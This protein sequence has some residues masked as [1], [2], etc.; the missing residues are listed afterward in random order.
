MYYDIWALR[1]PVLCPTDFMTQGTVMDASLGR[2]LAVHFA[3]S[4]IQVDFRGMKG[5]LPVDSA[6][7]GMGVYRRDALGQA[8]YIGLRD[9]R[10]VCEH[11]PLH[12]QLRA[13]GKRLFI[14]PRF[15]V[16]S[17]GQQPQATHTL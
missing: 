8:R 12:Q 16:A 7:G 14:S 2:P 13:Q 11:V 15:I 4:S 5:W 17:H 3:A 9:G 10:E 1:H 6:F